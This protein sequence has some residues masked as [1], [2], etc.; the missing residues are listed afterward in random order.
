MPDFSLSRLTQVPDRLYTKFLD[1]VGLELF[2]PQAA[3]TGLT[4]WLSAP[5]AE[6]VTVPAGTEVATAPDA[7]SEPVVFV[8]DHDLHIA[9]PELFALLTSSGLA[10]YED[11][12]GD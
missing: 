4:F 12:R 6:P 1:L 7:G 9:Q 8:S 5:E 10:R 11:A 2:P 3:V